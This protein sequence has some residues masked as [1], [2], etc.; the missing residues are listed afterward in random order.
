M[1]NLHKIIALLAIPLLSLHGQIVIEA[2]D[3]PDLT[4][5]HTLATQANPA[6][7]VGVANNSTA[8]VWDFSNLVVENSVEANFLL[9]PDVDTANI[10]PSA[11]L[12][13]I[14]DLGTLLGVGGGLDAFLGGGEGGLEGAAFYVKNDVTGR[15][16]LEGVTT[17]VSFGDFLDLGLVNLEANPSNL[18]LAAG[19]LGDNF[20]NNS[21]FEQTIL[22]EN[23]TL[24]IPIPVTIRFTV[25]K[26]IDI[27]AYGT[28][29]L[30][31]GSYETLRYREQNEVSIFIG[32][33]LLGIGIVDTTFTAETFRF[34]AKN[35]GYP[36]ATV[37]VLEDETGTSTIVS[38]E[39][40]ND[41]DGPLA[42][43]FTFQTDCLNA[44]FTNSSSGAVAYTWDFGTGDSSAEESPV[45]IFPEEGTYE[46]TL[47]ALSPEGTFTSLTKTVEISCITPG[48]ETPQ[49][50]SAAYPL[51][52]KEQVTISFENL[53]V[54]QNHNLQI[55]NIV[56]QT[57]KQ[58]N[59]V[60]TNTIINTSDWSTGVYLYTLYNEMGMPVSSG[61][62][63]K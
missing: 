31:N 27:D 48:I 40:I 52:A 56:G 50:K 10:Y 4:T 24:P 1:N 7:N 62:I 15:F 18:F 60:K 12:A 39:Y 25:D 36:V 14:G 28:V 63:I 45:Y 29:E 2:S 46:V 33:E 42:V 61:K 49:I 41:E 53:A 23:D 32:V 3:L 13:R 9:A 54:Q 55:T 38:A 21:T 8:Q 34:M 5:Q 17:N 26:E 16:F 19:E 11:E 37:N 6:I 22:V 43:N 59:E 51:P 57:I 30:P 35:V 20:S 58:F 44:L 47:T